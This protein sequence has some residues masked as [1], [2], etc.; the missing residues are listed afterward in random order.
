MELKARAVLHLHTLVN[1]TPFPSL[2]ILAM[3]APTSK[4]LG[5]LR[6]ELGLSE[7]QGRGS[8]SSGNGSMHQLETPE[9]SCTPGADALG[10]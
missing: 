7:G 1:H 3:P 10:E 8:S 9:S 4:R 2:M 5:R 6:Y